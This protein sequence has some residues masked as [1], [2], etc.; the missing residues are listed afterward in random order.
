MLETAGSTIPGGRF[1]SLQTKTSYVVQD[2]HA[3]SKTS[4]ATSVAHRSAWKSYIQNSHAS[5]QK[6][7]AILSS[8][9]ARLA[10]G[11]GPNPQS[12]RRWLQPQTQK[13]LP[14]IVT[15]YH[16]LSLFSSRP[17]QQV[18]FE[19]H[20]GR[21]ASVSRLFVTNYTA[22]AKNTPPADATVASTSVRHK[23]LCYPYQTVAPPGTESTHTTANTFTVPHLSNSFCFV[24]LVFFLLLVFLCLGL[25]LFLV[26]LL[27]CYNQEFKISSC[28]LPGCLRNKAQDAVLTNKTMEEAQA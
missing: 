27:F 17:L 13:E 25:C 12:M 5:T 3:P 23:P 21:N 6:R 10:K 28:Q 26:L 20:R 1:R 19:L 7:L 11:L 9:A 2:G 15:S 14:Q 16:A 24:L 4:E 18:L 8:C 22:L